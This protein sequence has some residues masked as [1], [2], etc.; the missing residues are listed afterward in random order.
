VKHGRSGGVYSYSTAGGARWRFVYR[1]T[2]GIQ[3]TKRGFASERAAR[4]ARRRLIEQVERGEV[5][6]TKETF[7]AYWERWLTRRRPYLEPGTWTGYEIHGR[8]RLVPA[9]GRRPLGELS[10]EDVRGFVAD[11]AE[12]VEAREIAA[13]TVNN[14]LVTLVVCLNDAVE[15]GLLLINPAVRVQR[16]PPAHIEREYLRLQEIPRYLDGCSDVYR[17]LAELLIGSGLRISEALALRVS[18]LELEDTGGAVIVYRSRKKDGTGSTKSDRFRSVEIGP[19]LCAVLRNQLARRAEMV[20]GDITGAVLFVMPVRTAKRSSGRWESAGTGVPLDR[21]TV[22]RDW[23]KQALQ[24]GALRDM[25]LH[26]LRHT[27][28]AAWLAAGNSLMYVQ[29]QLGHADIGTTERYYGHLERHVL[30]AGAVATE[31]AIARASAVPRLL[32]SA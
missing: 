7:G 2:D 29:R 17:P 30:A 4:D 5:R 11:L 31:E 20:A 32:Q 25:P 23:H 8:K 19:G 16:L 28:A 3:T 27:A 1:R 21:T 9:F 14:A 26:A 15:D 24:D 10:V 22:S 18:D 6:H 13:K 12:G